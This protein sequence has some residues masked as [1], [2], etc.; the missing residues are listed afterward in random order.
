MQWVREHLHNSQPRRAKKDNKNRRKN[1]KYQWKNQLDDR[2]S[3]GFLG[4]LAA[5][6]PH[7]LGIHTK[8]SR[9][10]TAHLF[11]LSE[12][13]HERA[14]FIDANTIGKSNQSLFTIGTGLHFLCR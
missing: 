6:V 12:K 5:F 4:G 7:G 3:R 2:L 13:G 1:E 11:C 9:N 8:R 10:A 14:E